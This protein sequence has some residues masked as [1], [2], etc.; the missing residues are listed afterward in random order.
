MYLFSCRAGIS[1]HERPQSMSRTLQ[2]TWRASTIVALVLALGGCDS[3]MPSGSSDLSA[4]M[5][6]SRFRGP[7]GSGVAVA[8]ALPTRF[9]PGENESWSTRL[10]PGH[11][12]PV[13]A[14]GRIFL[15]AVEEGTLYTYA[16]D[17]ASGKVLWRQPA[18]RPREEP[19]SALNNPASPTPA[20]DG[21]GV[22]VFFGDFGLIAYE[23]DGRERWQM[24]LG[25]FDNA[26]GMAASPVVVDGQVIQVCDQKT[27][28]F[29][30]S[31]GAQ[32]G[33]VRWRADRPGSST[34]H[35]T[36]IVFRPASGEVQLLIPGSLRLSAFAAATGEPRWWVSGLAFEMKAVPV[37]SAD[38]AT[39][40]INGTSATAFEDS[41]DRSV[42]AYDEVAASDADGDGIF[43]LDEIPDE[44]ARRWIRLI[45]LDS[46]GALN[47][48]EWEWYR[49]ARASRGGINAFKTGGN[50][51]MTASSFLWN[52]DRSVPQLPS[53]L[54]YEGV[55][56]MVDDGGIVTLLDPDSGEVLD[57]GRLYEAVE[58]YFASPI[59]GDGKVFMVSEACKVVVLRPGP[60]LDILAVNDLDDICFAT[61]AIDEDHIY[62]RTRSA[63]HAFAFSAPDQSS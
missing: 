29:M 50:G 39:V 3:T 13:V 33:E 5:G 60:T 22:Y 49:S 53:A 52:H 47:R 37:L 19:L 41:Y 10:P 1:G 54:L 31:V 55:I 58:S 7:N 4:D 48:Q 20:T 46:D 6:W 16:L 12:S 23:A 8:V 40:Y 43:Q 27:G 25:P 14:A 28:A 17:Q 36:P 18:P 2:A 56:H 15:T 51:D 21:N 30:I 57:R 34:G 11:S 63:L 42:P 59:A 44:L 26:Y 24:P 61:P 38:S 32:D 9:G 62:V 45:D 35:S